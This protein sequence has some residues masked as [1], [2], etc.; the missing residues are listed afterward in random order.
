MEGFTYYQSSTCGRIGNFVTRLPLLVDWKSCENLKSHN[1]F[2][3]ALG[4]EITFLDTKYEDS[5]IKE[6]TD[7]KIKKANQSHLIELQARFEANPQ[8]FC[9]F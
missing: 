5:D 9:K 7:F 1:N 6:I 4:P 2:I 8:T 3:K